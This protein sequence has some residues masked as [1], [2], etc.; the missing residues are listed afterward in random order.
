MSEL[1][2]KGF[3][4]LDKGQGTR[5]QTAF[6]QVIEESLQ[7]LVTDMRLKILELQSEMGLQWTKGSLLGGGAQL[8]NLGAYLTQQFQVPFNRFHQFETQPIA[9]EHNPHLEMVSG[10]AVG[11]AIEALRRP[12]NPAV[13]FLTGE[14]ARQ[15]H[16][17]EAMWDK[18]GYAAKIA[19][20]A[21]LIFFVYSIVRQSLSADLMD[22][23]DQVL[24]AQAE[25]VAGIK[26]RQ[27]SPSRIHR[28]ITAQEHLEKARKQ[29]EKVVHINSALDVLNLISGSLPGR[30]RMN[31]EIK[32][33]T[34][35]NQTAEVHGYAA[36]A[37]ERGEV[38]KALQRASSDGRAE[39]VN[40]RIAVPAGKVGFAYRLHVQRL[41]GG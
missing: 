21:F 27:A 12:R 37:A 31:V 41:A 40:P 14:F 25:A 26:A 15:S 29:A 10:V 19:G 11:L 24:R 39:A 30:G 20:A 22:R 28:F 7:N 32:R 2:S 17:F 8:K 1:Q 9:F 5:E 36:S 35:E 18:W 34:I 4:L 33:V 3:I 23:S 38:Q 13:D 6:S 16:F